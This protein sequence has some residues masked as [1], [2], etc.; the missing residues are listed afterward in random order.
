MPLPA[1]PAR[2]DGRPGRVGRVSRAR[3]AL[4]SPRLAGDV[5]WRAGRAAAC[6]PGCSIPRSSTP[7]NA[8][9]AAR[10]RRYASRCAAIRGAAGAPRPGAAQIDAFPACPISS[11]RSAAARRRPRRRSRCGRTELEEFRLTSAVELYGADGSLVSRFALNFPETEAAAQLQSNAATGRSS[12]R[13]SRS[14]PTSAACCTP[15]AASARPTDRR[16]VIAGAVVV[17]VM[18]DYSALRVHL[19]AEPVLRVHSR[20]ARRPR[21][22]TAGSDVELAIFGWGRL[23]IFTSCSRSWRLTDEVFDARLPLARAVLDDARARRRAR[24]RLRLERS[25]RHLRA[26]LS[27]AHAVQSPRA[28]R[29]ADVAGGADLP[30]PDAGRE[31]R[32]HG[33]SARPVSGAAAR[34]RDSRELLSQAVP[35]LRRGDG[36]PGADAG[37]AR[38]RLLRQPAARRRRGGGGAHGAHRPARDRGVAGAAA[39]RSGGSRRRR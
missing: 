28:P 2:A 11:A 4:V 1:T 9:S 30:R 19:V 21:E 10:S 15:S 39:A 26:R 25:Q 3:R 36:R 7:S 12:A 13:R 20:A 38:A 31:P 32:A 6:R 16:H 27:G 33:C 37:A 24:S 17:H 8:R 5:G 23:P 22:G 14:A 34:A 29:R 18:L 35:R